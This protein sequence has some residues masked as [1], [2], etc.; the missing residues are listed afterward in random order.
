MTNQKRQKCSDACHCRMKSES[1]LVRPRKLATGQRKCMQES[2][3]NR[4]IEQLEG[5]KKDV[6]LLTSNIF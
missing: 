3:K 1:R 4:L 5:G 2:K 6:I